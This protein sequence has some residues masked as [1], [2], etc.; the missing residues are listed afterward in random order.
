MALE[1][2][3]AEDG[4]F[5][6]VNVQ[7]IWLCLRFDD[8]DAMDPTISAREVHEG[9]F[10]ALVE[11]MIML[12][13]AMSRVC[14]LADSGDYPNDVSGTVIQAIDTNRRMA[15]MPVPPYVA[16]ADNPGT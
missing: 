15:I 12:S 14:Y 10:G 3:R 7:G 4:Y 8:W 1:S 6:N 13:N 16:Y 5:V 9:N 11:L 2:A